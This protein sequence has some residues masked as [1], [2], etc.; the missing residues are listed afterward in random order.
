MRRGGLP[1]YPPLPRPSKRLNTYARNLADYHLVL[2]LVPLLARLRFG[3]QLRAPLSP[4]QAAIL[5]G[6]GLQHKSVEGL[7]GELGL[8]VSQLLAL[9]NKLVRRFG[10]P[11][12]PPSTPPP[13]ALSA[14]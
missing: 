6:L 14:I 10:D 1:P 5:L 9:F 11:P 7:Q 3:E 13:Q 4:V 2:D 8:P 12:L